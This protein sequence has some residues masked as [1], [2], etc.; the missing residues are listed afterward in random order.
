MSAVPA[1]V[2]PYIGL[3]FAEKGR[4]PDGYDC[5]GLVRRVLAEQ[6]GLPLP[7]YGERYA[8]LREHARIAAAITD[9]LAAGWTHVDRGAAGD[10][11]IFRPGGARLHIGLMVT[12]QRFLHAPEGRTSC[13]ERIDSRLWWPRLEGIYRHG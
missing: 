2:E 7:D 8:T 10:V 3:P 9:G 4:G 12:P 5:W 6:F 13:I 1:W 11:A